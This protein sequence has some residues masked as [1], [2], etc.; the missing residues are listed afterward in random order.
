MI[1]HLFSYLRA[2]CNWGNF[3]DHWQVH[4][5]H[6]D[7]VGWGN[8]R[9]LPLEKTGFVGLAS[10][11]ASAVAYCDARKGGADSTVTQRPAY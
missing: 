5:R 1:L 10:V 8:P 7:A 11:T 3:R 4:G 9:A 2:S 6:W